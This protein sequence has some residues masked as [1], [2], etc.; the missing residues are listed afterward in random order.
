MCLTKSLP[1]LS[2]LSWVSISEEDILRD[3]AEEAL[4]FLSD[5]DIERFYLDAKQRAAEARSSL[6]A[7]LV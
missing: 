5:R 2:F 4:N 7:E 1:D 3:Q 6:D